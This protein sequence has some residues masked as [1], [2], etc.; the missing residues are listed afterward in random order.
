[1]YEKIPWVRENI[2][3]TENL[4]QIFMDKTKVANIGRILTDLPN[5]KLLIWKV[6]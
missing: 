3:K 6:H 1:M 2:I 4:N 5:I